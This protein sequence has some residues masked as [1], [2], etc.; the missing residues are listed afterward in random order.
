MENNFDWQSVNNQSF[1]ELLIRLGLYKSDSS[2]N[3]QIM[4]HGPGERGIKGLDDIL[5]NGLFIK[6]PFKDSN[7]YLSSGVLST[8][9]LINNPDNTINIDQILNYNYGTVDEQGNRYVVVT[10]LPIEIRDIILGRIFEDS[11]YRKLGKQCVLDDLNIETMFP[12]FILGVIKIR[13]D[14]QIE[15]KLNKHFYALSKENENQAVE[16]LKELFKSNGYSTPD[17]YYKQ[18]KAL[19]NVTDIQKARGLPAPPMPEFKNDIVKRYN[20]KLEKTSGQEF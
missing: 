15:F 11:E 4:C 1:L 7:N 12:Q 6:R 9:I 19:K 3:A 5:N 2:Q 10:A 18:V 20:R 8:N 16:N 17:E 13:P 14:K